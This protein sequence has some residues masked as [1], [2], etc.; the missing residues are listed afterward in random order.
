MIV[1]CK[2]LV[3]RNGDLDDC[4]SVAM[5]TN[6][7]RVQYTENKFGTACRQDVAV[8]ASSTEEAAAKAIADS[9]FPTYH[10]VVSLLKLI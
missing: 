10:I 5:T 9:A 7:Y 8:E 1:R 4:N 6:T 3:D 2:I